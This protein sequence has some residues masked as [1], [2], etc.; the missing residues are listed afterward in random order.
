LTN[1]RVYVILL[2]L[3][4]EINKHYPKIITNLIICP[5][6]PETKQEK[7]K[8][9]TFWSKES[10]LFLKLYKQFP[11]IPFWAKITFK[12][13]LIKNGRLPSFALFFDKDNDYWIN[14]LKNKWQAFHWNPTR[15]KKYNFNKDTSEQTNYKIRKK[16]IRHFFD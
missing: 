7:A 4:K 10:T 2:F 9:K 13:S 12:S 8:A 5:P 16:G 1:Y 6:K 11:S 15:H 3:K 14:L